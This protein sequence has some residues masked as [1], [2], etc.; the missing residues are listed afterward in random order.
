[1]TAVNVGDQFVEQIPLV[2]DAL[3]SKVLEVM[4]GVTT[5]VTKNPRKIGSRTLI[6]SRMPRRLR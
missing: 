6:D 3:G 2:G 5:W 1:V 4:M